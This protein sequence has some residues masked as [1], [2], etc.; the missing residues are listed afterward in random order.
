MEAY[1]IYKSEIPKLV[2]GKSKFASLSHKNVLLKPKLP[3]NVCLCIYH[4]NFML[5]LA[6]LH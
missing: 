1:S 6:A 3:R 4:E 5:L 2:A